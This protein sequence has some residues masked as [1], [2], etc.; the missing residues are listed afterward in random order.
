MKIIYTVLVFLTLFKAEL[1]GQ[2]CDFKIQMWIKQIKEEYPN[3]DIDR[4]SGK[5]IETI[6]Y[7]LYSDEYFIH[8]FKKPFDEIKFKK[9]EVIAISGHSAACTRIIP[10]N[11][12]EL[13]SPARDALGMNKNYYNKNFSY[14]IVKEKV[15]EIRRLRSEYNALLKKFENDDLDINFSSLVEWESNLKGEYAVLL[16]PSE[17][18]LISNKII[19]IKQQLADKELNNKL[20]DIKKLENSYNSLNKVLS[21]KNDYRQLILSASNESKN[22]INQETQSKVNKILDII[23]PNELKELTVKSQNINE[24]NMF[25]KSFS[26]KYV[27]VSSYPQVISAKNDIIQKKVNKILEDMDDIETQ[28]ESSKIVNDLERIEKIY[29]SYINKINNN[30]I[31]ALQTR[32]SNRKIEIN[33]QIKLAEQKRQEEIKQRIARE[34]REKQLAEAKAMAAYGFDFKSD[35]ISNEDLLKNI[36]IGNFDEISI[37]RDAIE[38]YYIIHSY[39][40]IKAKKYASYLPENKEEI[41]EIECIETTQEKDYWSGV[42]TSEYCSKWG[43]VPQGY[44]SSPELYSA[45]KIIRD[46]EFDNRSSNVGGTILDL[47]YAN[48]GGG[49]I[50]MDPLKKVYQDENVAYSDIDHLLA[51]N[52]CNSKS[53]RRFEEN[54]IRFSKNESPIILDCSLGSN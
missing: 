39:I 3:E 40:Y 33:R 18:T 48:K 5:K 44:F 23:I 43:E 25:Y 36:F 1:N 13:C 14:E 45:Y 11:N 2:Q 24:L 27:S 29:L 32:I 30:E 7:N 46:Y 10:G 42:V 8:F 21:F 20:N 51:L 26:D 15:I 9:L 16:L 50:N 53:I 4:V 28:V 22:Q 6:V 38:F 54:L 47:I 35:G 41:Y 19:S 17:I 37:K 49:Q 34:E 12:Y 31:Y 52:G